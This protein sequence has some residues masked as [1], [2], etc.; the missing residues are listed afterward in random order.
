[1]LVLVMMTKRTFNC[2]EANSAVQQF[3]RHL[4]K[5]RVQGN[6]LQLVEGTHFLGIE[7]LGNT[8]MVRKSYVDLHGIILN[9]QQLGDGVMIITGSPGIG[10]TFFIFYLLY[11]LAEQRCTV[12]YDNEYLKKRYMFKQG[13]V[14]VG[15]RDAFDAELQDPNTWC[16]MDGIRPN[17]NPATTVMVT[18]PNE[19]LYKDAEKLPTATTWYMPVWSEHEILTARTTMFPSLSED[20]VLEL[21]D[22][23]GGIPRF[24]LQNARVRNQQLRLQKAIDAWWD[25]DK[26]R[27]SVGA[28][29]SASEA[30]HRILHI[31]VEPDYI[32]TSVHFASQWVGGQ[33]AFK[34]YGANRAKLVEFLQSSS[35]ESSYSSVRGVLL[36]GYLHKLLAQGCTYTIKDLDNVRKGEY[37]LLFIPGAISY[38]F[39][40]LE[41]LRSQPDGVYCRPKYKRLTAVDAVMQPNKLFQFAVSQRHPINSRGLTD[42][43]HVLRGAQDTLQLLFVVPADQFAQFLKQHGQDK[44]ASLPIKQYALKL[45]ML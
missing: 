30:S 43:V 41:A 14:L 38:V 40:S 31:A 1:M 10:K 5:A 36:E 11:M 32:Q 37:E 15:S 13:R 29:E 19:A 4:S 35:A 17:L 20:F 8:L 16:L 24:L 12:V 34:L 22:K 23:W 9:R 26:M 44:D 2:A 45:P 18:P 21:F 6:F 39:D 7:R 3:W 25:V 33:I 27:S 28:I 42:A